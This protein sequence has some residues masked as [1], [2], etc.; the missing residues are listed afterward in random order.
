MKIIKTVGLI[1]VCGLLLW[2][3][4]AQEQKLGLVVQSGHFH[5]IV[6]SAFSQDGRLLAS[7]GT[8]KRVVLW[9]T[10]TGYELR[11]CAGHTSQIVAL[12]FKDDGKMLASGETNGI[13]KIWN[14]QSGNE[15]KTFKPHKSNLKTLA[16]SPDEKMLLTA[17]NDEGKI[18]QIKVWDIETAKLIRVLDGHK[19]PIETVVFSLDGT[20]LVSGS[21]GNIK[22]WSYP[23]GLLIKNITEIGMVK[24]MAVDKNDNLL[25]GGYVPSKV[26]SGFFGGEF[27]G[28]AD[29]KFFVLRNLKADDSMELMRIKLSSSKS[30]LP[31]AQTVAF[32]TKGQAITFD[33]DDKIRIWDISSKQKISET[34]IDCG[35]FRTVKFSANGDSIACYSGGNINGAIDSRIKLWNV[36]TLTAKQL[37]GSSNPILSVSFSKSNKMVAIGE[38]TN[39]I[40][41]FNIESSQITNVFKSQDFTVPS[42]IPGVFSEGVKWVAFNSS[43]SAI[44][45]KSGSFNAFGIE[46]VS[47]FWGLLT[48]REIKKL[49]ATN[50]KFEA[51]SLSQNG[52]IE[53]VNNFDG[54]VVFRNVSDKKEVGFLTP[55]GENDWLAA[56]PDGLF[57]G[58]TTAWKNLIWR[59]D[60]NTFNYV[61]VD[62]FFKEFYYPG[63]LQQIMEG[64]KP[65]PPNKDLL[66][67][68]IR[69]PVVKITEIDNKA[70]NSLNK[71]STNKTR[72][73]VKI[74]IE[75]NLNKGRKIT[76]PISSG[77]NDLRLFR[78]G[79]LVKIWE[80]NVFDLGEKDGCRQI[81]AAKN[82]PQKAVCEIEVA[83]TAEENEFTAYAFNHDN[84]KSNDALALITGTFD[85]QRGK[86]KVLAMGINEYQDKRYDLN[87]AVPDAVELSSEI[88]KQQERLGNYDALEPVILTNSEATGKNIRLALSRFAKGEQAAL[89]DTLEPDTRQKLSAIQPTQPEDVLIVYFSG[90]GFAD[91]DRFFLIPHDLGFDENTKLNDKDKLKILKEHSLSDI[92]LERLFR[93]VDAGQ[94]LFVID[95]CKSGQVLT[96]DDPRRGPMNSKGLAQLAYEK[97]MYILTASTSQQAAME[98]TR[99]TDGK[100]IKHG[101]LTYTLLEG[102]NT[103]KADIDTNK[104]V[105]EREWFA[106]AVEQVPQLQ[107]EIMKRKGE[108]IIIGNPDESKLSPEKRGLQTPRIFYRRETSPRPFVVTKP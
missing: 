77:A 95:A 96:A 26:G 89:P 3:A 11:M 101:L 57:D 70:T 56:T 18:Y 108:I 40:K 20:R 19:Y 69:Q 27:F 36:A 4:N 82:S 97:G 64:K 78:R 68:D 75:D 67:V 51:I 94:I 45:G 54:T 48:K 92:E 73:K 34:Q 13:V 44:A 8:D 100:E 2:S 99:T 35:E 29:E 16:F 60:N 63:L 42:P 61:S 5:N 81:S 28:W 102:L 41:I 104:E 76:F 87:F 53:I 31:F 33:N 84:V 55:I 46:P 39:S 107:L 6:T 90:H 24:S 93:E 23:D 59:F 37:Q 65:L 83:I 98:A 17:G 9:D 66:Q 62:A 14:V 105:I 50:D 7:G 80:R 88:L 38:E 85:K 22:I 10:S 25:V 30:D 15:I 71:L 86:L 74:E 43:E 91:G 21:L 1:F 72:V 47:K 12:A 52:K 32:N 103:A 106:Y 49:D 58:T 79:L